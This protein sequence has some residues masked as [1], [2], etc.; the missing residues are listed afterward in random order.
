MVDQPCRKNS[1]LR[2]H[3]WQQGS[4][5]SLESRIWPIWWLHPKQFSYIWQP[6]Q[7]KTFVSPH[8][9]QGETDQGGFVS[10]WCCFCCSYWVDHAANNILL[11]RNCSALRTWSK[12]EEDWSFLSARAT[13]K[14]LSTQHLHRI[15]RAESS[16]PIQL[17]RMGYHIWCQ[18][19]PNISGQ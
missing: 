13:I 7:P 2:R 6:V 4:L 1:P 5:P 19:R 15:V 11:R 3:R 8:E 9:D 14:V 12:S 18:N 16:P 17:Y 10:R